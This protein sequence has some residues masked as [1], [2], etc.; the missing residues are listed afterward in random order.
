MKRS[1]LCLMII[2]LVT[3]S[4]TVDKQAKAIKRLGKEYQNYKGY[5]TNTEI[6]IIT[7]DKESLYTI[8]ESSTLEEINL[9]IIKPEVSKG[10]SIKYKDDNIFLENSSIS[11]SISLKSIKDLNKDF[12]IGGFFTNLDSIESIEE[13]KIDGINSYKIRCDLKEK[14]KYNNK[15][16]IYLRKKDLN[17]L[18]MVILDENNRVRVTIKYNNFRFYTDENI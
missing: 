12:I 15:K 14:N 2:L 9:E 17:P 6:K 10:I 4:C 8:D 5:E 1:L 16:L 11:Q 7:D 3:V 18:S 13:E